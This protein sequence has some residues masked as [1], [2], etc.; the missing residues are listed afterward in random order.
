LDENERIYE[1]DGEHLRWLEGC[2]REEA[3]RAL[4]KRHNGERLQV[5]DVEDVAW[6]LGISRASLYR[7]IGR[8]RG[9]GTVSSVSPP[10]RG[11][12]KGTFILIAEQEVLIGKI[13]RSIYLR[14]TRATITSL[15]EHVRAQFDQMGWVPPDRRTVQAR[16]DKIDRRVRSLKRKDHKGV[17]ATLPVPGQYNVGRP[18][19]VVQIDHTQ[20][21]IFLVDEDTREPMTQRPWL[22]LAID[23]FSRMVVGFYVSMAR[24]SRVSNG[25]CML[26]AVYDKTAWLNEREIDADWPV[27]GL[28]ETIHVDN[29]SDF[30]SRV[31]VGACRN[32]GVHVIFR[33]PGT[34]RYGGHIERLIGTMMG[35]VHLLPGSTSSNPKSRGEVDPKRSSVMTLREFECV[36]G[37]EIAGRYH[38]EIHKALL[39]PPIAVWREHE[40][41]TLLRMPKDRMQF[42]VS[43]LPEEH[44]KLR[45]DGVW[46]HD[47][48]YWSNA[49]AGD[50]GRRDEDLLIKYDPRD[51]S[52]I[53]VKRPSG[54]YIEARSRDLTF[55]SLTLREWKAIHSKDRGQGRRERDQKQLYQAALNQRKLI[56]DAI[57]RTAQAQRNPKTD[58]L[59]VDDAEFGSLTGIDT[60]TP[61]VMELSETTY[62]PQT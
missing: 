27:A 28:P 50:V 31:F 13:I 58:K 62:D 55:P 42:F 45:P 3:I 40:A 17:K 48:P 20:A 52:H 25:L 49:L 39:R 4:L 22:T 56:E 34:P 18:L 51:V 37:W 35:R 60:R 36:L 54:S 8:Y 11:R 15:V 30:K 44:R 43:F 53:F 57:R 6:E 33:P 47:I 26:N 10:L 61:S 7:L 16:V 19:E 59:T 14:E 23:V 32:E 41:E 9:K 1:D 12:Q 24:P 46:L 5:S 38:Y 21:D 29:G 2:R